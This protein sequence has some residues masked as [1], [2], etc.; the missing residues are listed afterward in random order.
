MATCIEEEK[1]CSKRLAEKLEGLAKE[2]NAVK[3]DD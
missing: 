2:R 3:E 1:K